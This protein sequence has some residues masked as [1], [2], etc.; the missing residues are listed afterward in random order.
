M[1]LGSFFQA[2]A[3]GGPRIEHVH[4]VAMCGLVA[5]QRLGIA[6]R[7]ADMLRQILVYQMKEAHVLLLSWVILALNGGR[8]QASASHVL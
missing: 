3:C 1:F 8:Y 6:L 7:A 2:G 4:F 5:R